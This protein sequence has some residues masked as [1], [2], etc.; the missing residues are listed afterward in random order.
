VAVQMLS[1]WPVLTAPLNGSS[2]ATVELGGSV[3]V[4]RSCAATA[5][6]ALQAVVGPAVCDRLR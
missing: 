1:A 6:A 4:V 3:P 5:M 2:S